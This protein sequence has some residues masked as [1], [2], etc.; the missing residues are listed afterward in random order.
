M[1]VIR[2]VSEFN[3]IVDVRSAEGVMCPRSKP[4]PE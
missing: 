4:E 2:N 3:G 1:F